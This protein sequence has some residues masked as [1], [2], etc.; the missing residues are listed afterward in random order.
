[1]TTSSIGRSIRRVDGGEKV[2]GLTR[3]AG[4]LTLPG[5]VHARLVLSP[6]AHA[7]IARIDTKA[8][9]AVP[10]VLGVFARRGPRAREA[11]SEL[12]L[13]SRPLALDRVAVRRAS[14]RRRRRGDRRDRRGRGRARRGAVRGAA[15]GRRRVRCDAHGRA[16][17]A[18]RAGAGG[19]AELAMH[20]AATGAAQAPGGRRAER[21]EHAALPSRRRRAGLRRGGRRGRA[22]LHDP[23]GA[24]GLPRAA[25]RAGRRGPAR[26]AHRVDGDPGALLHALGGERGAGAAGAPSARS[27]R[28]PWAAASA[29]SSCCWSRWR[30]RSRSGFAGR[31]P[32]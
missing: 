18:G 12:A 30:P 23:D 5:S 9:A 20:G 28:R 24:P 10:G 22:P 14:G 16:A 31:C 13:A 3:Y 17:R 6:H 15:A 26:R 29:P 11:R 25:G 4:D 8:A 19:E 27:W 1:M 7:R 21:R 2:T 32:S